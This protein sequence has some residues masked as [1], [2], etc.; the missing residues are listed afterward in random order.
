MARPRRIDRDQTRDRLID[1]GIDSLLKNGYH[2]TGLKQVLDEVQVPKGSFYNYFRSKDDFAAAAIEQYASCLGQ[3]LAA[4][5]EGAA[6]PLSGLRTFF[7]GQMAEFEGADFVG[8]CLVANLGS[9]LEGNDVCRQV[10]QTAMLGYRDG[11]R[12]AIE[13]AQAQGLLRRDLTAT[14]MAD[15]LVAAWEGA[16]IRMKVERSLAPLHQCLEQL[17]DGYFQPPGAQA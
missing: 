16:V 11:L 3:T 14:A 13:G 17:L 6:D 10:L 12:R 2:G 15:L 8:G 7:R 4:A 5:I 9:E 1:A